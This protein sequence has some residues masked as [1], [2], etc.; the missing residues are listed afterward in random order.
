VKLYTLTRDQSGTLILTAQAEVIDKDARGRSI[1]MHTETHITS[2]GY[3]IGNDSKETATLAL[4][5]MRHY[6]GVTD[7]DPAAEAEAER[8]APRFLAAYLLNHQM[9]PNSRYEI[10]SDVLDR[11]FSL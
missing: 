7:A 4:A 3:D 8:K 2:V 1:G 10:S 6:Y 5:I 9:P 11:F